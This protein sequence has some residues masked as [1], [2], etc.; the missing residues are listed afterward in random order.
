MMSGYATPPP[1]SAPAEPPPVRRPTNEVVEIALTTVAGL[2]LGTKRVNREA[3]LI[4]V[5]ED[6]MELV[7]GHH[8]YSYQPVLVIGAGAFD[9]AGQNPFSFADDGDVYILM[10]APMKDRSFFDAYCSVV[11]T[12]C[13]DLDS[14]LSC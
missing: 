8:G 11:S 4:D 12:R 3:K 9:A 1:F 10:K 5:F 14:H 13:S 2:D 6:L 7:G